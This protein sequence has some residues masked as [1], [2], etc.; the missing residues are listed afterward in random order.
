M[1]E[2]INPKTLHEPLGLYSHT[3]KIAPNAE[4]LAIAGQVGMNAKGRVA[5]GVGRQAEQAYRNILACLRAHKMTKEH[6]VKLT[7]YLTDAHSVEA[8]RAARR[9]V[10][11][12]AV[13]PPSTLVII[14]GLAAPEFLVE[15]EAWAAKS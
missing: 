14:D 12:D 4:W 7:I 8:A 5:D 10:L 2:A 1:N 3:M 15:I 6:L 13:L 11:G 9:K